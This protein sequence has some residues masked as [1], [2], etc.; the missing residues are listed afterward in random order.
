MTRKPA[1]RKPGRPI[2]GVH[3]LDGSTMIKLRIDAATL[4]RLD[5]IAQNRKETRSQAIRSLIDLWE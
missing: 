3:A 4:A 5:K 2:G 1:K